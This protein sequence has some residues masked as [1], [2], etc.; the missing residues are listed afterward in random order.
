VQLAKAG[1]TPTT[2]LIAAAVNSRRTT[3]ALAEFGP[4]DYATAPLCPAMVSRRI[5]ACFVVR[6]HNAQKPDYVFFEGEPGRRSANVRRRGQGRCFSAHVRG[7]K[8]RREI[9]TYLTRSDVG[10]DASLHWRKI[11][12]IAVAIIIAAPINSPILT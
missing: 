7:T 4:S 9:P 12:H 11:Y 1:S 5:G 6:D 3:F 8:L 2:K 10:A